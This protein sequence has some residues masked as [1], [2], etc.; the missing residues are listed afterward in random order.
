[1]K[2]AVIPGDGIGKEVME[3]ALHVLKGLE[4][5][6]EFVY[7][8]AGD[9]CLE[10][11]GT[12]LP[13]ETIEII[14]EADATLFGAAGESAADVIVKLRREFDLFANLRPVKSLPGV[15]CLYPDLDF[16]IVRENTED[17]YVGDEEFT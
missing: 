16:V 9:E 13:D 10:R 2:I 12:A 8:D 5:E 3:A 1:M 17:L 11:T 7:A 15:P 6:L 4:L 14:G